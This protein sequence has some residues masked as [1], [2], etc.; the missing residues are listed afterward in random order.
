[1]PEEG[2]NNFSFVDS[3]YETIKEDFPIKGIRERIGV[4]FATDA[5]GTVSVPSVLKEIDLHQF[6]SKDNT[7]LVQL[8]E[9][10]ITVNHLKVYTT[11]EIFKPVIK[12]NVEKFL[13]IRRADVFASAIIR[14]INKVDLDKQENFLLSDYFSYAVRIPEGLPQEVNALNLRVDLWYE[15]GA[16]LCTIALT[17]APVSMPDKYSFFFDITYM[18]QK[19]I[20]KGNITNWLEKAHYKLKYSF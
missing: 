13:E 14:Y 18:A 8:G 9:N 15:H 6:R 1:M 20:E 11:W 5:T 3:Y 4:Q 19:V 7:T 10:L 12:K 16:D 17:S 2:I